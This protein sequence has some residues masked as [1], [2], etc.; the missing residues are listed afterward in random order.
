MNNSISILSRTNSDALKGKTKSKKKKTKF[1]YKLCTY[2]ICRSIAEKSGKQI[3]QSA[4]GVCGT[5]NQTV[6]TV[7]S[8]A[9]VRLET[10]AITQ[11]NKRTH[12]HT[13]FIHAT[14]VAHALNRYHEEMRRGDRADIKVCT[15]FLLHAWPEREHTFI[16]F[17]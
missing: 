12:T 5:H 8:V 16:S 11:T 3:L 9:C 15:D 4:R 14:L 10:A 17:R 6:A 2:I 7:V 1:E 13:K